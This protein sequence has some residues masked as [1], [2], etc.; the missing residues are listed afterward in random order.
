MKFVLVG[1]NSKYIHT[2][3]AIRYLRA[4]GREET[5]I[6]E[7]TINQKL[8]D[9]YGSLLEEEAQ[10]Y[11]FSTY[12][13]NLDQVLQVASD[14]KKVR[15]QAKIVLG[16]PEVSFETEDL[17]EKNPQIDHVLLGEGE[18]SFPAYQEYCLGIREI[19]QVPNL[20]YREG[21]TLMRTQEAP[22][23]D[24]EDLPDPYLEEEDLSNRIAYLESS[25]GCPFRCAFCLSSVLGPV[26]F[27]D[28]DRVFD[29]IRRLLSYG[30]K[31]IKFVD[32]TFN[33]DEDKAFALMDFIQSLKLEN[34]NF[35][36]EATAHLMSQK[37]ISYF[38]DTPKGLFQ[39]ELGIQSTN[40]ETLKAIRRT[41]DFEKLT[42]VVGKIQGFGTTHQHV[43][44]ILGLPYEGLE[45]FE[46]SFNDSYSLGAEKI[47]VGFLKLLKGSH[48]RNKAQDYGLIYRDRPPYEILA[49][50]WLSAQ[51]VQDLKIF[52]DM[53][54]KFHNEKYFEKTN[55]YLMKALNL[56][57]YQ[58]FRSLAAYYKAQGH[59]L[60]HHQRKDLYGILYAY[61]ENQGLKGKDLKA[62]VFLDYRLHNKGPLPVYLRD[63]AW[64]SLVKGDLHD[65][66]HRE[67]VQEALDLNRPKIKDLI[68]E[69]QVYRGPSHYLI[70]DYRNQDTEVI[71]MEEDHA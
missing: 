52:E 47:Q 39:L 18:V 5:V 59:H 55:A 22:L 1:I 53:V 35:H 38:K 2:N 64:T 51:E 10:V 57:P 20:V 6:R 58:Y 26:R 62:K 3:L 61:G 49:T 46:K 36:F 25:R 69:V 21:Q 50:P 8:D 65:F 45:E 13:W 43:D 7:Y 40:P 31:Q 63:K 17:M 30:V 67:E 66:L 34:F 9:I 28:Q 14:L 24:L 54:D 60:V 29:Q 44:L 41:M 48:L 33:A 68:K 15:P 71:E 70:F 42:E 23:L 32:R 19:H 27:V 12:I 56:N 4:L 11:G 37:M 16:G